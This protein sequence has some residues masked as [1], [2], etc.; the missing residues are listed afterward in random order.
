MLQT[1][2]FV[3]GAWIAFVDYSRYDETD[4]NYYEILREL[5]FAKDPQ[6]RRTWK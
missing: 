1:V 3:Y 5:C 2:H 4:D 6:A